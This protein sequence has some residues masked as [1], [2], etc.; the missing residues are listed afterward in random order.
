M[1]RL[2]PLIRPSSLV[3]SAAS[4]KTRFPYQ[5]LP[6]MKHTLSFPQALVLAA[7]LAVATPASASVTL[8]HVFG[9]HMVLQRDQVLPVWGWAD[10]GEKVSVQIGDQQA[11]TTTANRAGQWRVTLPKM[12]AGGPLTLTVTG[13]NSITVDDVLVGEVWLCSGQSNMEMAVAS[14]NHA[15]EEIASAN[16]PQIRQIA[17]PKLVASVTAQD[18]P[19]RGRCAVRRRR[20]GS[21][22]VA[23]SWRASFTSNSKGPSVSW[24]LPGA[25][26]PSSPGHRL[27]ALPRSPHWRTSSNRSPGPIRTRPCTR[28]G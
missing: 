18:F 27:P 3:N 14:C 15:Q 25:A 4:A 7:G 17:V 26:R 20:A 23:T 2:R 21:P 11:V 8:P 19:A 24:I 12:S 13:T 9:D 28:T 1:H 10:P 5:H 6:P 22:R 16:Y